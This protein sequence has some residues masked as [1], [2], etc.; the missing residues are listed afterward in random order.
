MENDT[1]GDRKVAILLG[2]G[3]GAF[4]GRHQPFSEYYSVAAITGDFNGDG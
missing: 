1:G 3:D 4:Q 2:N